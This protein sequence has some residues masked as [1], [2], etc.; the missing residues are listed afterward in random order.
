MK[1]H[2]YSAGSLNAKEPR[3]AV[4]GGAL[5]AQIA[6][7]QRQQQACM[8]IA[9]ALESITLTP[10]EARVI[11]TSLHM[12]HS[13]TR[14]ALESA[15]FEN[16]DPNLEKETIAKNGDRHGERFGVW[17]RLTSG[18]PLEA[19]GEMVEKT[20]EALINASGTA[21][22][23]AYQSIRK[24][25]QDFYDARMHWYLDM[26]KEA[27]SID[28]KT[29]NLDGQ[30]FQ[31]AQMF[32]AIASHK[33]NK[34]YDTPVQRLQEVSKESMRFMI[35]AQELQTMASD[36]ARALGT[37][38]ADL[39]GKVHS[40][41]EKLRKSATQ[42]GDEMSWSHPSMSAKVTAILARGSDF[43]SIVDKDFNVKTINAVKGKEPS[44]AEGLHRAYAQDLQTVQ[45]FVG[46]AKKA[47]E[48][49]IKH[50]SKDLTNALAN[51]GHHDGELSEQRINGVKA[52]V[53]FAS[54]VSEVIAM[55]AQQSYYDATA[56]AL[57]WVKLSVRDSNRAAERQKQESEQE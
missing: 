24:H 3:S 2:H 14:A 30:P 57:L 50:N 26:E 1:Q 19:A 51:M 25:L 54:R 44:V 5:Y 29:A 35:L 46:A 18:Q 23:T 47:L 52:L 48:N 38:S 15:Y 41:I 37:G 28:P 11:S 6:S 20:A 10:S 43:D 17:N 9:T 8:K 12:L 42:N 13:P 53:L 55:T 56:N 31:N 33:F 21:I 34:T 45:S 36:T 16:L 4:A 27:M 39:Q 49:A 22:R 40:L 32:S 7:A